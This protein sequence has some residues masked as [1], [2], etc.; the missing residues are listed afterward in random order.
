MNYL[1][2]LDESFLWQKLLFSYLSLL[3][4]DEINHVTNENY[5]LLIQLLTYFLFTENSNLKVMLYAKL[6]YQFLTMTFLTSFFIQT[7]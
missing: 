1:I 2:N 5:W 6:E 4:Q 7:F 3:N